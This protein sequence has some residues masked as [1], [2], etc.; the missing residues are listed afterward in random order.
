MSSFG[1]IVKTQDRK[2]LVVKDNEKENKVYLVLGKYD[3]GNSKT[4]N[5]FLDKSYKLRISGPYDIEENNTIRVMIEQSL[6]CGGEVIKDNVYK[7]EIVCCN[8]EEVKPKVSLEELDN[9][10]V[11]S[12]CCGCLGNCFKNLCP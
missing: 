4:A 2:V 6:D 10:V 9:F 7:F 3:D 8:L 11:D 12:G 5:I 1:D